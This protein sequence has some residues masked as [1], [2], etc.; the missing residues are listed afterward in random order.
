MGKRRVV[1]ITLHATFL[2][3]QGAAAK[4]RPPSKK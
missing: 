3:E 4:K 1:S 2:G